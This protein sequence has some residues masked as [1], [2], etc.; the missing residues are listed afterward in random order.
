MGFFIFKT[1][2]D[3]IM[4]YFSFLLILSSGLLFLVWPVGFIT[5]PLLV[6][7]RSSSLV[8]NL[9]G[10]LVHL[11]NHTSINRRMSKHFCWT[12]ALRSWE[13]LILSLFYFMGPSSLPL[14]SYPAM[15]ILKP[16]LLFWT[17]FVKSVNSNLISLVLLFGIFGCLYDHYKWVEEFWTGCRD[18]M[19]F[20]APLWPPD[21]DC[22]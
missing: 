1:S 20:A 6:D 2:D 21:F 5:F 16:H 7:C 17:L 8:D 4:Y 10:S 19:L 3:S 14:V 9:C 11:K 22:C 13:G 12:R 15:D 18:V